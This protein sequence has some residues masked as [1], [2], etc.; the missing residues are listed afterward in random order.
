[1]V[2][3]CSERTLR[4]LERI[5]GR[6][7]DVQEEDTAR[8]R[9][10]FRTHNGSLPMELVMLV[11]WAGRAVE[12]RVSSKIDQLFLDSFKCHNLVYNLI[13]AKLT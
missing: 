7:M 11:R 5:V 4:G 6:E 10:I 1:M 13:V 2:D 8:V 3:F 12:R 9:G